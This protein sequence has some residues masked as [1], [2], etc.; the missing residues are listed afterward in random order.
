MGQL[1]PDRQVELD[2]LLAAL[3]ATESLPLDDAVSMY[4]REVASLD[5]LPLGREGE[6]AHCHPP[7]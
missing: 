3:A 5:L 7:R 2:E 6:L 1:D 4:L